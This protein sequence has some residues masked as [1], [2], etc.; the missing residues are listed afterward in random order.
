M[1][2]AVTTA[3]LAA[4]TAVL[5]FWAIIGTLALWQ[6][7]WD[8][9]WE[10]DT[11][12]LLCEAALERRVAIEDNLARPVVVGRFADGVSI[13][14]PLAQLDLSISSTGTRAGSSSLSEWELER[15]RL[16]DLLR[17]N[18]SNIVDYCGTD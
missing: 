18:N 9:P 2:K 11:N 12:G 17:D 16:T 6:F 8:A 5:V 1:P 13:T 3:V 15:F 14:E 10:T 4:S 7:S